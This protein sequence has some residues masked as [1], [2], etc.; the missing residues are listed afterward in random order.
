MDSSYSHIRQSAYGQFE[1]A[2]KKDISGCFEG[3][4]TFS[5]VPVDYYLEINAYTSVFVCLRAIVYDLAGT[6]Q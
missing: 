3:K 1:Q 6:K 5:L 4:W 2:E